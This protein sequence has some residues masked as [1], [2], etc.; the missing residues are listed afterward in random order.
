M[1]SDIKKEYTED[2]ILEA[3]HRLWRQGNLQWKLSPPQKRMYEFW[4]GITSKTMVLNCGRRIG[5]TYLL[6]IL[7]LEQALNHP[8]STIKFLQPQK[9]QV[10]T[11]VMPIMDTILEDCP[12]ELRPKFKTAG[13]A[14]V[15]ANGSRIQLGGTDNNSHEKL[16]GDDAHLCLIDEAGFLS[17]PLS[18][19]VR[20]ILAPATMR[21]KGK[22][23]LSSSTPTDTEHDFLKYMESAKLKNSFFAV[24]TKDALVEHEKVNDPLFTR[25][26]YDTLVEEYPSGEADE[27]FRRECLNEL[28]TDGTRA[29]VPEF[30]EDIKKELIVE[31]KRPI[32]CDKYVSMDVG[33][34]DL[35]VV[36]FGFYDF[37]NAVTV[38]EDEIVINGPEL[39][40]QKLAELIREKENNLWYDPVTSEFDPPYMR[41]ADNNNLIL[42]NDLNRLHGI[43]FVP[44]RK[45]DKHAQVNLLRMEVSSFRLYINPRCTTLIHHVG[46]AQW[47]SKRDSFTRSPD[48]GHYDAVDALIYFIRNIQKERNPFPPGYKHSK[49]GNSNKLFIRPN[50]VPEGEPSYKSQITRMF[51]IRKSRN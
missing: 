49:L 27:E 32:F 3:R 34:K 36:L 25:D 33:M 1:S 15:F 26:M 30:S 16:R 8:K 47:N 14:Y 39:T 41:V 23:I 20:S 38:I 48:S 50:Y 45:D 11:N 18:Y 2:E 6:T 42:L 9:G 5:K 12:M 22:I 35:T 13:S 4:K 28:V 7:A 43:L 51:K 37:E 17:A 10:Q 44:T 19:I 40:T 21:T 24:T 46:H 29:V 31:W